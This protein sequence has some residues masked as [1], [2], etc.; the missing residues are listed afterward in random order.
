MMKP[1]WLIISIIS[2]HLIRLTVLRQVGLLIS[3]IHY[4]TVIGF[5]QRAGFVMMPKIL[6]LS[7]VMML[8]TSLVNWYSR[9]GLLHLPADKAPAYLPY[10]YPIMYFRHLFYFIYFRLIYSVAYEVKCFSLG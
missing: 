6:E 7:R 4:H 5:F 1:L 10:K 3:K 9:T 2:A 8:F